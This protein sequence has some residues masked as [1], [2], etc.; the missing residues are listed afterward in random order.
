MKS[1]GIT[2]RI[3]ELGRIVIPKEI[4]KNL[5]LKDGES[6][7]I[8]INNED[9][10]LKKFSKMG[11]MGEVFNDYVNIVNS[12]TGS[13]ILITDTEK[14]ISSSKEQY[15]NE[16]ISDQIEEF[17]ERRSPIFTNSIKDISIIK[18]VKEECN[19][20]IVPLIINSDVC[21]LL[22]LLSKREIN[23]SDKMIIDIIG[24]IIVKY[25]E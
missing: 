17:L 23:E 24:K 10:V 13:T 14:V 8:F 19:Y 11:D 12:L 3:D 16:K 25:M 21:G 18:G 2:R 15:I 22:I 1:T 9:I 5:R 4:R 6:L 7:E 20:Y